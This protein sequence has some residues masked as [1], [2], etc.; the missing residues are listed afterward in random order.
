MTIVQDSGVCRFFIGIWVMFATT[1]KDSGLYHVLHSCGDRISSVVRGSSICRFVWREGTLP[2]SWPQSITCRVL[3]FLL[4][5]PVALCRWLYGVG[6]KVWD[7][8]AC[9]RALSSMG[10]ASFVFMGLFMAVMLMAPHSIWNNL[11]GLFGAVALFALFAVGSSVRP[12]ARIEVAE[13]GPYYI[14][15]MAFVCSAFLTSLSWS[16]SMRFVGFHLAAFLLAVLVVSSVKSYEQI[17]TMVIVVMAGVTVAALYGC[18]QGVIGVEVV[19]NQQDMALNAGMPGRVYSFFDNPNNFAELLVMLTPLN[20]AIFLNVKD[21]RGKLMALVSF[22]ICGIA[23]AFTYSRSGWIGFALAT[24]VFIAFWNWKLIPVLI[25][26]GICCIPLL[27]ETIY[28]RIL[29]I[30][31]TSDS[32]TSYRFA[33]YQASGVLMK[34]YWWRGVG[35]GSDVLTQAFKNYP[36]MFDG[37]YPIHTHN[38]Y[39][40]VWAEMGILGAIAFLGAILYQLKMGIKSFTACKDQRVKN[41]LAAALAGFCGILVISIAE[42]TWF[43]ARNMF[44]YFFLF[45]VVGVCIKLARKKSRG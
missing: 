5:I 9:F 25:I 1:W 24:V 18:Y 21:W 22:G 2:K 44:T 30:G 20:Y 3:S 35:L 38:N 14:L 19:A 10:G 29:T 23:L 28:N 8:S 40:Q 32:S 27:P 7:G 16:Q 42:Y 4:N 34:D 26:L 36:T 45:G 33:I 15:F 17:Q 31:N 11:Y 39:L 37:N 43:Y 13:F 12:K 41:M 6:R